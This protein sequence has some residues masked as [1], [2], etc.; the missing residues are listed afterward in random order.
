MLFASLPRLSLCRRSCSLDLPT[1]NEWRGSAGDGDSLTIDGMLAYGNDNCFAWGN[2]SADSTAWGQPASGKL[3]HP[4][5]E[6]AMSRTRSRCVLRGMVGWNLRANAV[7]FGCIGGTS[8]VG[9]RDIFFENCDFSGFTCSGIVL[10]AC[11]PGHTAPCPR[12]LATSSTWFFGASEKTS[13][14]ASR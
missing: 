8:P 12:R 5:E 2:P 14:T 7:R 9:I 4:F 3:F 10:V 1:Q 13:R 11:T 6:R